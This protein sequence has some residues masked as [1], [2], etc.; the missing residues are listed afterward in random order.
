MEPE[1]SSDQSPEDTDSL[2]LDMSTQCTKT[3][4]WQVYSNCLLIHKYCGG[5]ESGGEQAL[6]EYLLCARHLIHFTSDS[7]HNN[8]TR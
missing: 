3:G 4:M 8:S 6:S 7:G 2:L 5:V 1:I